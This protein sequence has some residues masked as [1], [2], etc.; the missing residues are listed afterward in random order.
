MDEDEQGGGNQRAALAGLAVAVVLLV[1]GW[2][3]AHELSAASRIQD[4]VMSGRRNCDPI[5][6]PAQ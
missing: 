1:V 5:Q 2:W 6:T 3:L 4:C